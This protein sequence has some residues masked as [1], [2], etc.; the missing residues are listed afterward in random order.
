MEFRVCVFEKEITDVIIKA[1]YHLRPLMMVKYKTQGT[2]RK[3]LTQPK[4][5]SRVVAV[6]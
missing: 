5:Q 3:T 2:T 1:D 4:S 6:L